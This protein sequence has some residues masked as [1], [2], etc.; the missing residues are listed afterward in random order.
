MTVLHPSPLRRV[1]VASR[2]PFAPAALAL[3]C[4]LS[5]CATVDTAYTLAA[6]PENPMPARRADQRVGYFVDSYTD[7]GNDTEGDRRTHLIR[8]WRLQKKDPA[9]AVS[10]PKEPVRVV[11]D[12]NIPPKW[13]D[14]VR[15]AHRPQQWRGQRRW[16][17]ARRRIFAALA[18]LQLC[19]RRAGANPVRHGTGPTPR[20]C[21]VMPKSRTS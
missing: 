7:F 10:E 20:R 6:L 15:A 19:R 18:E 3:A 2:L 17:F 9:A 21:S 14:A 4:L 13:R 11:M 5:P 8:R 16:P 1:F 12:R